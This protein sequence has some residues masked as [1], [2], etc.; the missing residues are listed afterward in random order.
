MVFILTSSTIGG[1]VTGKTF[2]W[3]SSTVGI[4]N[5]ISRGTWTLWWVNSVSFTSDTVGSV[6]FTGHTLW[7]T[8][9]DLGGT[10]WDVFDLSGFDFLWWNMTF[11]WVDSSIG[12]DDTVGWRLGTDVTLFLTWWTFGNTV[13]I[14]VIFTFTKGTI[15]SGFVGTGSTSVISGTGR[16]SIVTSF[17]IRTIGVEELSGSTN[18]STINHDSSLSTSGT[19][20]WGT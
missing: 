9:D 6:F 5:I 20:I 7:F 19:V 2:P 17:T 4:I 8:K 12:T 13:V 3:T 15:N 18:T 14:V 11:W 1:R 10:D 16:T